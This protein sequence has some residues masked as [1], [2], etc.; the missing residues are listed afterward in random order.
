M[1]RGKSTSRTCARVTG[2]QWNEDIIGRSV[3]VYLVSNPDFDRITIWIHNQIQQ[4]HPWSN[5]LNPA[6]FADKTAILNPFR[7]I[8]DALA[9]ELDGRPGKIQLCELTLGKSTDRCVEVYQVGD[10]DFALT[11]S[12]PGGSSTE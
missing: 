7:Q 6:K 4:F 9:M 5:C 10:P 3:E 8:V 12:L 2:G 1:H 11:R